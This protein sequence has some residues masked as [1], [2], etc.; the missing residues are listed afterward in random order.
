M[1]AL[2]AIV[3]LVAL[4]VDAA[5]DT[6]LSLIQK[7]VSDM[8]QSLRGMGI[9]DID[10]AAFYRATT[11]LVM[12]DPALPLRIADWPRPDVVSTN[13]A[14][15]VLGFIEKHGWMMETRAAP[16][17]AAAVRTQP[18]TGLPWPQIRTRKFPAF[19]RDGIL[20]IILRGFGGECEGVAWNPRTNRFDDLATS[21]T[22]LGKS[23]YAWSQSMFPPSPPHRRYE[24]EGQTGGQQH[25]AADRSQPVQAVTNR[26]SAAAGSGR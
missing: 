10:E 23:W 20:Y 17:A 2:A 22:P 18:I 7:Q 13:Q 14:A 15:G 1:K 24:G 9:T 19:T 5:E 25:G 16:V 26:T 21:F 12:V 8:A 11:N 3:A 6:N 4:A